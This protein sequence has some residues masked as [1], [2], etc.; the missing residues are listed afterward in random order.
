MKY[1]IK[2][3]SVKKKKQKMCNI[4]KNRKKEMKFDGFFSGDL[5][6]KGWGLEKSLRIQVKMKKKR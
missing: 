5:D 2:I 3:K 4:H 1:K 6:I